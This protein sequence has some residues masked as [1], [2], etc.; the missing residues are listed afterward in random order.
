MYRSRTIQVTRGSEQEWALWLYD[1]GPEEILWF[2]PWYRISEFI[3]TSVQHHHVY[4]LGFTHNTWYSAT[5]VLRQMGVDKGVPL[6]TGL[7]ISAPITAGVVRVVMQAWMRHFEM[8]QPLP[9]PTLVRTTPEHRL[10]FITVVWPIEKPR[11]QAIL[12]ELE[13]D[14]GSSEVVSGASSSRARA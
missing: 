11:R 3:Q 9:D 4:L 6:P 7:A 14:S 12:Q 13:G 8:V 2:I 1:L 10:W 5:R